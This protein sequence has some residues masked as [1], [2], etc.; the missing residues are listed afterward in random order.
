MMMMKEMKLKEFGELEKKIN[1]RYRLEL[2]IMPP[3]NSQQFFS[4]AQK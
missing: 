1:H 4:F 3:N 2:I